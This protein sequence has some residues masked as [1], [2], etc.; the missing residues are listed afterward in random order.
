G[1]ELEPVEP[2]LGVAHRGVGTIDAS[3]QGSEAGRESLDAVSVAHPYFHRR[4]QPV[5]QGSSGLD[6]DQVGRSILALS[7]GRHVPAQCV[8]EQLHAVADAEDR[9]AAPED[10]VGESG[11][12]RLVYAGRAAAQ[13]DPTR[14]QPVDLFGGNIPREQL[15]VDPSF[16]HS[17][18][19]Q[20]SILRSKVKD[21]DCFIHKYRTIC[22]SVRIS[23]KPHCRRL[24]IASGKYVGT[25][26]RIVWERW[27][28]VNAWRVRSCSTRPRPSG[29]M[30]N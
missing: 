14:I 6:R 25:L 16:T 11:G 12:A 9:D 7:G 29:W 21:D 4:V 10:P 28:W 24:S 13:D 3:R 23:L 20:L 5:K 17:P 27:S 15:A 2:T 1:V 8:G 26:A 18:R 22:S 19:D 30:M